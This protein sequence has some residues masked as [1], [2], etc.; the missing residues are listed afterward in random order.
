MQRPDDALFEVEGDAQPEEHEEEIDGPLHRARVVVVPKQK[1]AEAHG[2]K[3]GSERKDS[4]APLKFKAAT[5]D[6]RVEAGDRSDM[7]CR[8][9]GIHA[10]MITT[11]NEAQVKE[12]G[13][14][15]WN[16]AGNETSGETYLPRSLFPFCPFVS[17]QPIFLQAAVQRAAAQAERFG[18]AIGV[19]FKACEGFCYQDAFRLFQTHLLE[20]RRQARVRV[21]LQCEIKG[22]HKLPVLINRA[23][24]ITWSSSRTLPGHECSRNASSASGVKPIIARR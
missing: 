5:P 20:P 7:F 13:K 10:T 9:N 16:T 22:R 8:L 2:G 1:R 6:R 17:G 11:R 18:G 12:N 3:T 15:R 14:A 19:A 21:S 23:R 4:N 24:S